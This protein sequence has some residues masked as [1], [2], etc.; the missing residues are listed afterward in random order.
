M[1]VHGDP[2]S[3][4]ALATRHRSTPEYFRRM[5][6]PLTTSPKRIHSVLAGSSRRRNSSPSS[7]SGVAVQHQ[8]PF[9]TNTR[10][11][12]IHGSSLR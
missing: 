4:Q 10:S 7:S 1:C 11:E 6:L 9:R 8:R 3:Y 5:H 12:P 2:D